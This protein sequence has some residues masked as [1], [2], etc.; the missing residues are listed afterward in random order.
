LAIGVI[1]HRPNRLPDSAHSKVASQ[2]DRILDV[3]GRELES[4]QGRYPSYF[5]QEVAQD[6]GQNS[7]RLTLVSALAEGA[8]QLAA[9]IALEKKIAL[10]VVLPMGSFAYKSDFQG[11]SL[12]EL[13]RL[14]AGARS[15][16][17]LG[18]LRPESGSER[19]VAYEAGGLTVLVNSDI[20]LVV[21][22]NGPAL[23]LG[24]TARMLTAAARLG[25]PIIHVD[26][27]G[28]NP[29]CVYWSGLKESSGHIN[30]LSDVPSGDLD[31][32]LPRVLAA[33]VRPPAD[34]RQRAALERYFD[35]QAPTWNLRLEY[36]LLMNLLGV[37]QFSRNDIRPVAPDQLAPSYTFSER[38][39]DQ[40]SKPP[41]NLAMGLAWSD[42]IA[43]RYAQKF[44]STFVTTF[45]VGA[46]AVLAAAA[47]L[48]FPPATKW[49]FTCTEAVLM[50]VILANNARSRHNGWHQ[51]WLQ[52]REVAERLRG[53]LPQWV[54]GGR[55]EHAFKEEETWPAWYCRAHVRA[56]GMRSTKMDF[57]ALKDARS[58]LESALRN[59]CM[60]HEHAAKRM[61]KI[62]TRLERAGEML[63]L[64]T[65][66][67]AVLYTA[68]ALSHMSIFGEFEVELKYI[69]TA[70][71]VG[72][73]ALATAMDL[74]RATNDFGGIAH[75]SELTKISLERLVEAIE[76]DPLDLVLLRSRARAAAE[77]MLGDVSKWR[78]AT[79]TRDLG[80]SD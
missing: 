42:T 74:L 75:R 62:E 19:A 53:A 22:D 61:M 76:F 33:L 28:R 46:V 77:A 4:A 57:T 25:M 64:A 8:D 23:G 1:G 68:Y 27:N 16:L 6:V 15:V 50:I 34:R 35:E 26:A 37:R 49:L 38:V 20:L 73:P 52:A 2:I 12:D 44:R 72:L 71:A 14:L 10:D 43:A 40:P 29:T 65:L 66:V 32:V 79:E 51:R 48:L 31:A 59:Q 21:W 78:L 39:T 18:Y 70:L 11:Q 60:Y 58:S 36:P 41:S 45:I 55:F 24:G 13:N 63:F 80:T 7:P 54:L 30:E 67:I 56:A 3:V 17:E 69:V 47:S 9:K 5:A